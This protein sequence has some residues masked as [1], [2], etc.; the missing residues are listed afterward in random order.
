[1]LPNRTID[2]EIKETLDEQLRKVESRPQQNSQQTNE[3][4][5]SNISIDYGDNDLKNTVDAVAK[6]I[7]KKHEMK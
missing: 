7:L 4:P 6:D 1:M 3:N 2:D 5:D